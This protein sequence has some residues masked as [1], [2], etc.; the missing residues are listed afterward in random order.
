MVDEVVTL[1]PGPGARVHLGCGD[2]YLDGYLNVDLPPEQGVASGTSSPDVIADI[3]QLECPAATLDEIRLHHVFEHF[4]RAQA[5]AL[6]IRWHGWLR[7]GGA[8]VIET[9]DFERCVDGIRERDFGQQSL[10]LRHIFGSQEAP[11]ARHLDGW[12]A[13]RFDHVLK[14][15]G[16]ET[17]TTSETFSDEQHLLI[18]VV[19][20][21]V[22]SDRYPTRD[23][24]LNSAIAI[25][26]QSMN[27][28]NATEER[29]ASRWTRDLQTALGPRA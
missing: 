10:I 19:A 26:E 7:A 27:G 2:V 6:L 12:S 4:D 21:A 3:A 11:W 24:Q 14:T 23:E 8:L 18:N 25:L 29:L 16:F 20:R 13:S 9:P 28:T 22:K 17:V 1:L 5:L 15:L